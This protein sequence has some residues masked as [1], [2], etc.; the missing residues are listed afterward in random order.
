MLFG[1]K[2]DNPMITIVICYQEGT[3]PILLANLAS[4]ERH[5]VGVSYQIL[6]VTRK[7]SSDNQQFLSELYLHYPVK[8][9]EVDISSDVT[10][11]VHG[12]MLDTVIPKNIET[13]YVL[14]L[15]SDCFPVASGWLN[16]LLEMMQ[17]GAKIVGILHPWAPPPLNMDRKKIEFRVRTQHCW[18]STHVACQMLK[19]S[20][21]IS[22]GVKYNT[23]DD[24]GLAIVAAAKSRGWKIDGFKVNRCPLPEI[25]HIDPEFNRYV[26]LIFGDKVYH[27]GGFTRTIS[28]GDEP[29]LKN[30]FGW[31]ENELIVKRGAEFLLNNS[32]SYMFKFDR[33]EEVA[34]EKMQRLFGL[35]SQVMK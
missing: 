13:E 33:E 30:E 14:T 10:S 6:I 15:D 21:L 27:H 18:E 22:L 5:S 11:H 2:R 19:V 20:D 1:Q 23:G 3:G 29:V 7:G 9:I 17:N 25:G 31:V 4:I 8:I 34:K 12:M 16:D 28:C 35:K 26:C 24:T 32:V